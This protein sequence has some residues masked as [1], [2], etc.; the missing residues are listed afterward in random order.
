VR[1]YTAASDPPA[2]EIVTTEDVAGA[3]PQRYMAC[4]GATPREFHFL[5]DGSLIVAYRTTTSGPENLY[6]LAPDSTKNCRVLVQYTDLGNAVLSQATDFAV[7]PD[8]TQI[9]FLQVDGVADDA[10]YGSSGL[11]G[12]YPYVVGVD[13]GAPTRLSQDYFM[14]GPR[15]IG[16]GTRLVGARYD[17]FTDAGLVPIATSIIVRSPTPGPTPP[18]LVQADGY[19]SFVST[20]SNGGCSLTTG[21]ASPI[22][23][24]VGLLVAAVLRVARRRR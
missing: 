4:P 14:Y 18:P 5:A 16:A 9:A 15:W 19:T 24:L 7:S 13:G 17:G 21:A 2:W 3:M 6:R 8:G 11:P 12:G 10:S 23:A 1:Q 20:G 22:A